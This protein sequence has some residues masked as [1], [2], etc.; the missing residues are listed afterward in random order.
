MAGDTPVLIQLLPD[1]ES[2]V[3]AATIRTDSRLALAPSSNSL[4][5]GPYW[6]TYMAGGFIRNLADRDLVVDDVRGILDGAIRE[7][8]DRLGDAT[9]VGGTPDVAVVDAEGA[10]FVPA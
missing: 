2:E 3:A 5:N 7:E 6:R 1:S 8:T 9:E 10:R 4:P